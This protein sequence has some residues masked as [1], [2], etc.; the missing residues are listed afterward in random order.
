MG[1]AASGVLT[2]HSSGATGSVPFGACAIP[3]AGG[4]LAE[5]GTVFATRNAATADGSWPVVLAGSPVPVQALSGGPAGNQDAATAY[6]WDPPLPGI[7]ATSVAAAG[8]AGGSLSGAYAGLRQVRLYKALTQ[9]SFEQFLRAQLSQFPGAVLAWESST[10]L[11]GPMAAAPGP[12][13]AR[14]GRGRFLYRHTWSLFLVESRLDSEAERRREGDTLRDD[15]IETLFGTMRVRGGLRVS[16]EPGAEVLEAR[17]FA[18]TPSSYVDLVRFGTIAT[19]EHRSSADY[20]DWL[21]TQLR[22]QTA[23]QGASPPLDLPDVTI[24]MT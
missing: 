6:R 12:R 17:V 14:V 3:I 1:P 16:N 21:T 11:D 9:A 5:E 10:P 24:P 23:P 15:V 2:V 18:V 4:A 7:E 13:Q 19:V 20:N 8:V 22:Q